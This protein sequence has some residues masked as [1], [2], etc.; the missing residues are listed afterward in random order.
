MIRSRKMWQKGD[1]F[2]YLFT[3]SL[4]VILKNDKTIRT[5][6]VSE[7]GGYVT[8]YSFIKLLLVYLIQI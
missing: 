3:Y 7:V 8:Y 6:I 5:K 1:L 2:T 4:F